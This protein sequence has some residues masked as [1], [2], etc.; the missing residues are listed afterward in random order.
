MAAVPFLPDIDIKAENQVLDR[1]LFISFVNKQKVIALENDGDVS[2]NRVVRF[3][4]GVRCY[5]EEAVQSKLPF[6][7]ALLVHS[8]FLNFEQRMQSEYA[9]D[10]YFVNRYSKAL[11]FSPHEVD[12]LHSDF[13]V[14]Q[15]LSD[16]D[17]PQ[18]IWTAATEQ[19]QA[20]E[21]DD[22]EEEHIARPKY[23][24]ADV[25]WDYLSNMKAIDGY[26]VRF[27]KL[28]IIARLVLTVPHSNTGE[29][30]SSAS[31]D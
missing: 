30:G 12:D 31:F 13:V 18:T 6:T 24:R 26:S 1:N 16:D 10:E 29:E 28:S 9:D 20:S 22:M 17:I 23:I 25:I 19:C 5:D 21:D 3:F 8:K 14:Y 4:E 2:R 15:L 7:A 11:E 27:G